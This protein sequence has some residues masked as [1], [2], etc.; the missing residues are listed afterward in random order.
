MTTG[1][2]KTFI[3]G[4]LISF[5]MDKVTGKWIL[6]TKVISIQDKSSQAIKDCFRTQNKAF[7]HLSNTFLIEDTCDGKGIYLEQT[8]A[9]LNK[10]TLFKSYV[11]NY[12]DEAKD[13]NKIFSYP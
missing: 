2:V 3:C 1:H 6:S 8:F 5:R 4:H 13:W 7:F 11:E 9:S 10:Y 12:L